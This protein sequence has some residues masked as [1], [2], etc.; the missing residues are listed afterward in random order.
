MR[1]YALNFIQISGK[2][3]QVWHTILN[4]AILA[5]TYLY[6]PI[7]LVNLNTQMNICLKFVTICLCANLPEI[8]VSI[9]KYGQV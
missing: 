6:L 4:L 5:H 7:F 9:G 3:A 8:L 2:L 1:K